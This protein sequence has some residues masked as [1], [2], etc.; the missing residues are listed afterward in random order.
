MGSNWICSILEA[1]FAHSFWEL[2][3][4]TENLNWL[5]I[6]AINNL[7]FSC[8][9][10]PDLTNLDSI[11]FPQD[12]I[13]G[14]SPFYEDSD[15]FPGLICPDLLPET[16]LLVSEDELLSPPDQG[17]KTQPSSESSLTQA[18]SPKTNTKPLFTG[19]PESPSSTEPRIE[20]WTL[21]TYSVWDQARQNITEGRTFQ[22]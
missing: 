7:M 2:I 1:T 16:P 9:N 12:L 22:N 20:D 18:S 10:N 8:K 17:T 3:E 14:L 21:E 13:E 6:I 5:Q 4:Q 15:L 11:S 19:V